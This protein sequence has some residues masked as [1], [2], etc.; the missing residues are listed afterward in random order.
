MAGSRSPLLVEPDVFHAPTV[1]HAIDHRWQTFHLGLPAGRAPR[2]KNDRPRPL[3]LQC[4]I[5][6]PD[7]LSAPLRVGLARLSMKQ[8]L[9]PAIAVSGKV[10]VGFAS[11]TL[12]QL[13]IGVVA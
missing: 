9:E 13:L 3:L 10:A 2:M 8:I 12:V 1:D 6:I 11:I 5:D 7:Q 4:P